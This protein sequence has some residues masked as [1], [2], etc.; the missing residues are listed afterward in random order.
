MG[1]KII[2]YDHPPHMPSVSLQ[3][4][5]GRLSDKTINPAPRRR[6]SEAPVCHQR[7]RPLNINP[8]SSRTGVVHMRSTILVRLLV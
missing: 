1:A 3:A 6:R 4:R 8:D 2:R 5:L 7:H